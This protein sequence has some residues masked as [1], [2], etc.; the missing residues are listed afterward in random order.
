MASLISEIA[1]QIP[2]VLVEHDMDIVF[3]I[4][5]R[6]IVMNRGEVIADGPPS[7]IAD[8][9]RVKEIYLGV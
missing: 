2:V 1:K 5:K 3:S 6:I 4:S 8:N 7:E 9:A